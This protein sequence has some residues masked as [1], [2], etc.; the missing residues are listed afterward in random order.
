MRWNVFNFDHV[1]YLETWSKLERT[2]LAVNVELDLPLADIN[3][4]SHGLKGRPPKD[5]RWILPLSHV[6]YHKVDGDEVVSDIHGHIFGDAQGVANGVVTQLQAH[7]LVS[8][9]RRSFSNTSLGM[10]LKLAPRSHIAFS[11]LNEPTKQG[12]IGHL[13]SFCFSSPFAKAALYCSDILT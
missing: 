1:A 11:N 5:E 12:I 3:G 9:G 6:E 10:T 4:S 7:A 13:G 8:N 2:P